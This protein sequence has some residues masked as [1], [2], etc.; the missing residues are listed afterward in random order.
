[1]DRQTEGRTERHIDYLSR[2]LMRLSL[3]PGKE[4]SFYFLYKQSPPLLKIFMYIHM[5]MCNR[6][7]EEN[8]IYLFLLLI[9]Y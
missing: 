7:I 6:T 1:M 5:Y 8:F 9:I 2:Y 3:C 4:N